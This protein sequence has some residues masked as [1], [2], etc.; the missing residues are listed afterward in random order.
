MALENHLAELERRHDALDREISKEMIR[1]A[2]DELKLLELKRKKL[3]LKDEIT[4]LRCEI[5]P[6]L[7]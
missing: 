5:A 1:P 3:L 2:T 7:H 4:K 6:T